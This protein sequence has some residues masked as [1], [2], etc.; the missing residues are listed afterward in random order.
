MR[1]IHQLAILVALLAA[2]TWNIT[3]LLFEEQSGQISV[4][5]QQRAQVASLLN[6]LVA[7]YSFDE[8]NG[9]TAGDAGTAGPYNGTLVGGATWT[10]GK[11]G[12]GAVSFNG[13]GQYVDI[14]GFNTLNGAGAATI[15]FWAHGL[16]TLKPFISKWGSGR[17]FDIKANGDSLSVI[18]RIASATPGGVSL[19]HTTPANS[20]SGSAWNHIVIVY[21]NPTSIIYINGVEISRVTGAGG[22]LNTDVTDSLKLGVN[23][24]PSYLQ[25]EMDDV[26]LYNRAVGVDEVSRLYA[27]GGGV[28]SGGGTGGTT[29]STTTSNTNTNTGGGTGSNT[30][31]GSV[32]VSAGCS[33]A[34]IRCVPEEFAT[35][36]S[37]ADTANPGDICLVSP[38]VYDE[39]VQTKVG[40]TSE[41][42]RVVFK[43][44]NTTGKVT[45]RGFDIRHPYVTIDGFDITGSSSRQQYIG[46]S[47][48]GDYCH[49]LNNIIR[50]GSPKITG[51][52]FYSSTSMGGVTGNNCLIKGN[53][54]TRLSNQ[55]LATNG[56][57]TRFENNIF[58]EA[59]GWDLVRVFGQD[60]VFYRNVFRNST[61]VPGIGN[62][63]DFLQTF[64]DNGGKS[65]NILFEENWIENLTSGDL[66]SGYQ[67][68]QMNSGGGINN[69]KILTDF[70]DYTFR[71]NVF[72]NVSNNWN[73]SVPG[74]RFENNTFVKVATKQNGITFGGSLVR[75]DASRMNII[76]NVML[77]GG[78]NTNITGFYASSGATFSRE[79]L[80]LLVTGETQSNETIIPPIAGGIYKDM[81]ANGY[82]NSNGQPTAKGSS[83]VSASDMVLA[84]AYESY[85]ATVWSH[86]KKSVD[87]NKS[88]RDTFIA[89]YNY[90]AG[91]AP[92]YAA[93]RADNCVNGTN[94]PFLFCEPHG[95]N[96]GD[97]KLKNINDPDGPDNI[98][99]TLDDGFKPLPG[100]PLCGKGANGV[101][102][103]AYSCD[104]NKVFAT[105]NSGLGGIT[106][107]N[108]GSNS[109]TNTGTNTNNNNNTTNNN[110]NTGGGTVTA[111]TTGGSTTG[112]S[113]TGGSTTSGGNTTPRG[114]TG[115]TGTGS[116]SV[117]TGSGSS[118][119]G[120][121]T[122]TQSQ[123]GTS[124][125][126]STGTTGGSSGAA[127]NQTNQPLP[128][129]KTY[130]FNQTLKTGSVGDGV[131]ILQ[132]LLR[133]SGYLVGQYSAGSFD[134]G[135]E[136]AVK[137]F[138]AE[139]GIVSFGSADTTGYGV[140]GPRTRAALSDLIRTTTLGTPVSN[141]VSIGTTAPQINV[142]VGQKAVLMALPA[143]T[144]PLVLGSVG[145][146]VKNLQIF[147]NNTGYPVATSG[148]GSLG[149]ETTFFGPA[150][151][152]ALI[153]YQEANRSVILT[154]VG[155]V[156]GTGYFGMS[157][158][159][160]VNKTIGK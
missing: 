110:S 74:F 146:D 100:S 85:R 45:M 113:T 151:R 72:T 50:D 134:Q 35:I 129:Y 75:G 133:D 2:I 98:P 111:T 7:H 88:I 97:P 153:R 41:S 136:R 78:Q 77:A 150:T 21:N 131:A 121:G 39:Q 11:V 28:V 70:H 103:G 44:Q 104:A 94:T 109:N 155:L 124:V 47:K 30:G 117:S 20:L 127:S 43:A 22:T 126:G 143:F 105:G 89:D 80:I 24:T 46:I 73:I 159:R 37:C 63:P 135:T 79:V 157:T 8:G 53:V 108:T 83:L 107:P 92:T 142:P 58:E 54:F 149:K 120:A 38:G 119:T 10:A 64:G 132:D 3:G 106:I 130:S 90:V 26:R 152:R 101:D 91:P 156:N 137:R 141:P 60:I 42:N 66:D 96:G 95:I 67:L 32:N 9:T 52:W 102:V 40:G 139:K 23:A 33:S 17:L 49:V 55:F 116:G 27:L 62:H 145:V 76:N 25:G 68:G 1:P 115:G 31:T 71:R 34:T 29:V 99:F 118:G 36:Q 160:K 154:P 84:P 140:L 125:S 93:K 16:T 57:G 59:G 87:L 148:V 56:N 4:V 48:G 12:S 19:T 65:F 82:I 123:G 122:G 114:T 147:L 51:M 138:Q 69:P 112:G 81:I 86:F 61:P 15:S 5:T 6:G 158:I 13:S 14:P 18:W 128:T 144:R